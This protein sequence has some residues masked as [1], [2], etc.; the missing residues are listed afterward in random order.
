M[1]SK[2]AV[3]D[4]VLACKYASGVKQFPAIVTKNNGCVLYI[5]RTERSLWKHQ[6]Q[7]DYRFL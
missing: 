1:K 7:L 2:Y 6:N 4:C 5:L 3:N